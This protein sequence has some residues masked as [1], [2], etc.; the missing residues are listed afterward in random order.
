MIYIIYRKTKKVKK[1]DL[2]EIKKIALTYGD[3]K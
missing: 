2:I 1:K 3:N